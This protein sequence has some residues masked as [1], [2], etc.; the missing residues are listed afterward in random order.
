MYNLEEQQIAAFQHEFWLRAWLKFSR[1]ITSAPDISKK[2][3]AMPSLQPSLWVIQFQGRI[4]VKKKR[5]LFQEHVLT[6]LS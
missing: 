1:V 4:L 5:K 6:S 3:D 2:R